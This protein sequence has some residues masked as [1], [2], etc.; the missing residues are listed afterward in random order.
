[1]TWLWL[2]ADGSAGLLFV[3]S[4]VLWCSV[5]ASALAASAAAASACRGPFLS[6]LCF[7]S[8]RIQGRMQFFENTCLFGA[9]QALGP[10]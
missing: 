2:V 4:A 3:V 1:M 5:G 7:Y 6:N 9:F 10:I 8:L